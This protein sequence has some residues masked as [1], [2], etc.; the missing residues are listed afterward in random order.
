MIERKHYSEAFKRM[1]A[2]A[3]YSTSKS[4]RNLAKEYKLPPASVYYW[5]T[6]YKEGFATESQMRQEITTFG[7]VANTKTP[8]KK[9]KLTEEH[10]V[11]RITELEHK[12]KQEMMHRKV[13]DTMI[14]IA[15]RDLNIAIRKKS[16]AKQSK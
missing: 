3:Y 8:M 16:G 11:E 1:V 14:D 15:E 13:L 6:L 7:A 10:M 4:Y 2:K 12:L 5:I 9:K